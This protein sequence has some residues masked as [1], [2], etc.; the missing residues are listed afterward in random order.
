MAENLASTSRI[1]N[2]WVLT[3]S[4][5]YPN[6]RV[7]KFVLRNFPREVANGTKFLD[8][9]CGNGVNSIFLH[10]ENFQVSGFD[11]SSSGV[12]RAV[13]GT[14]RSENFKV[15]DIKKV[16]F[17][18]AQFDGLICIGVLETIDDSS[19]AM[20]VHE[21]ARV[22]APGG[23]GLFLFAAKGDFREGNP[24]IAKTRDE[25]EVRALFSGPGFSRV[26]ID[27]HITTIENRTRLNRDWLV[28]VFK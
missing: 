27:E 24:L 2:E 17:D 14:G 15:A 5:K 25:S 3:R 1:W 20:A 9:G 26:D 16:P 22:L 7:I 21:A 13:A 28:T 6:E 11:I 8:M 18:T 23:K 4:P 19:A 12:E 10:N